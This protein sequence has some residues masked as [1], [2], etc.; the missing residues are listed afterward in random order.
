[1]R[2]LRWRSELTRRSHIEQHLEKTAT[3]Y[4]KWRYEGGSDRELAAKASRRLTDEERRILDTPI[5]AKTGEKRQI[6]MIIGRQ[7]L[8]KSFQY[9]IKWR[10]LDHRYNAWIPRERL[11]ELGF[12]K[13]VQ[14][15]DDFEVRWPCLWML[16]VRSL[17]RRA[18]ALTSS[19]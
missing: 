13:I 2:R 9:E 19:H 8:K 10:N 16:A 5:E 4:I 7:K 6:E 12:S 1:M 15:F 18:A 14:Q 3:Q 11:I 17:E